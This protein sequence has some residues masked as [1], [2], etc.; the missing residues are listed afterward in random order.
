LTAAG[1]E[2]DA[3]LS[4][5][6]Q[7]P[8][9]WNRLLGIAAH[10]KATLPVR[11]RICALAPGRIPA[12]IADPLRRSALVSSFRQSHLRDRLAA[13]V[14]TLQDAGIPVLLLKG[15]ALALT[16]YDSFDDRP[17]GDL[18][19]LVDAADA[20][21]AQELL[22]GAGWKRIAGQPGDEAYQVHQHLPPLEDASGTGF[23]LELHTDLFSRGHPFVFSTASLW[24][25]ARYVRLGSRSV[26]VPSV[27]HALLHLCVHFA[28]SHMARQ[29]A[30]RA[31]R[32]LH[33]LQASG[34]IEWDAFVHAAREARAATACYWTLRLA[35]DLAGLAV[36]ASVLQALA[37]PS[38]R[39]SLEVLARHL[40][41][42][43]VE[44]ESDCPSVWASKRMWEA[45]IRP[46]WS[47]HGAQRPW[48]HSEA[49][50][51]AMRT[52]EPVRGIGKLR[53][54]LGKL[55]RWRRYLVT[56]LR[57]PMQAPGSAQ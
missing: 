13:A 21:R 32:D 10:Q 14:A 17:M 25:D 24:E 53:V 16:V 28:W 6:L 51:S 41:A 27:T 40:S 45:A 31:F 57:P 49:F 30:W 35:R 2:Q 38:G 23:G 8:L 9:D 47:G 46:R 39:R 56:L 5:W 43:V 42:G 29:G 1:P 37:P 12:A 7:H 33:A 54:H 34:A 52:E 55:A 36:P 4:R 20:W 19:L 26:A 11:R 22:L 48:Q 44:L 3:E 15:A 18:D 50:G